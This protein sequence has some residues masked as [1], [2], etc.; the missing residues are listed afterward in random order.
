MYSSTPPPLGSCV[1]IIYLFGCPVLVTMCG[2]FL[3][4]VELLSSCGVQA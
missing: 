3:T 2:I 1:Y 4:A